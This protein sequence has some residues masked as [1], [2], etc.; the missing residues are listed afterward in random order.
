MQQSLLS[1]APK[2]QTGIIAGTVTAGTVSDGNGDAVPHAAVILEGPDLKNA[3]TAVSNGNGF[4]EF[5]AVWMSETTIIQSLS[6]IV[7]PGLAPRAPK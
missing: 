5:D 2:A 6:S 3:R 4:F 1:E 7:P